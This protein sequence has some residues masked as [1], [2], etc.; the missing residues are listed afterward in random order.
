MVKDDDNYAFIVEELSD[1]KIEI[2]EKI[3]NGS[4]FKEL[5]ITTDEAINVSELFST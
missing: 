5:K 3:T 2:E 1:N 4:D